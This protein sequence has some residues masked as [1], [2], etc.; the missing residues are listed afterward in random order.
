MCD[1]Y[2]KTDRNE[3][4]EKR[5]GYRR[6]QRRKKEKPRGGDYAPRQTDFDK[7]DK[8]PKVEENLWPQPRPQESEPLR[9][10]FGFFYAGGVG[11][12]FIMLADL[13]QII[14]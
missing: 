12:D 2:K 7:T 11:S 6:A 9:R 13:E 1:N 5:C 14:L 10:W 8:N 3:Q 4:E